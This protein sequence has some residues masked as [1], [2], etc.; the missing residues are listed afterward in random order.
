MLSEAEIKKIF[1]EKEALLEGHF[2]LTSGRHSAHYLQ[3]AKVLQYP[4]IS[5]KLGEAV[6]EKIRQK[7]SNISFRADV[8]C[9]PAVG[10]IVFG[11]VVARALGARAVF[12]EREDGSGPMKLRRGFSIHPGETVFAV[13]DVLTTGGSLKEIVQLSKDLGGKVIGVAAMAERSKTPLDFGADK[14]VLLNL[15]LVDYPPEACPLCKQEIPLVKPGS[16]KS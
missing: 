4:Y 14:V 15:P 6:A 11:H 5:E 3:C 8:V 13:E 10:A 1:V 7:N 2:K 12:A 9:S 16:R